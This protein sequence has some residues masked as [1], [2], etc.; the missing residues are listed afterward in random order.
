MRCGEYC[1]NAHKKS[2]RADSWPVSPKHETII[3]VYTNVG[4]YTYAFATRNTASC[5]G[6]CAPRISVCSISALADGPLI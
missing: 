1:L 5:F 3:D 4:L 2:P 6:P